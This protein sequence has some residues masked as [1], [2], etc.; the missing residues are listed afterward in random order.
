MTRHLFVYSPPV[1]FAAQVNMSPTF[2]LAEITFDNVTVGS[3]APVEALEGYTVLYGSTPGADD[4]GRGYIR[5]TSIFDNTLLVGYSSRGTFDGECNIANNDYI[6]VIADRR[7]WAKPQR[8]VL[9]DSDPFV[10]ILKDFELTFLANGAGVEFMPKANAGPARA[11]IVDPDTGVLTLDF[12][13]SDSYSNPAGVGIVAWQWDFAD[14]TIT[15][16]D[17]D[18]ETATVTFPPGF[19]YVSLTVTDDNAWE[20][21]MY[22]PVLADDPDA[23]LCVEK[24]QVDNWTHS[25]QGQNLGVRIMSELPRATYPD[26]AVVMLFDDENGPDHYC[27][28][29]GWHQND[30]ANVEFVKTGVLRDT[31]LNCLDVAGRLDTLPAQTQVIT[32]A[33]EPETWLEMYHPTMYLLIDYLLRWHSTALELADWS[34]P[35]LEY[36]L[37]FI[38]RE[39]GADTLYR[40][41]LQQARSVEVDHNV[42]CNRYG[43]LLMRPDPNLQAS[44]SRTATVQQAL[45]GHIRS[46]RVPHERP[47]RYQWIRGGGVIEGWALVTG[48]SVQVE[49]VIR[50][51]AFADIGAVSIATYPLP[52]ALA[53]DDVLYLRGLGGVLLPW[54]TVSATASL[55]ATSVSVDALTE[56]VEVWS[57]LVFTAT[58]TG[59]SVI[60]TT[61]CMAPGLVPG[62]GSQSM[63][64]NNKLVQND[65]GLQNMIGQLYAKLNSEWGTLEFDLVGVESMTP[66]DPAAMTWVTVGAFAAENIPQR[67]LALF[68]N[69]AR[70]LPLQLT[71][72]VDEREGGTFETWSLSAIVETLGRNAVETGAT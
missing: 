23:S 20:H 63:T 40:Q 62:Q 58:E 12:D 2:P 6:T 18:E 69:G 47:P 27:D 24:W 4:K 50:P 16:G 28:F 38:T 5:K 8:F 15:A 31:V 67:L 60:P 57:E 25:Q 54:V 42:G 72:N 39:A 44:I 61:F 1:V 70:L 49:Y 68:A 55:G 71:R 41:V 53:D 11:G 46:L 51:S 33:D 43:Q 59:P 3:V 7:V 14:G 26:G 37:Q 13:A 19:R 66:I 21:T 36:D 34:W 17:D 35:T 22:V 64:V 48:G 52:V 30:T 56:T 29:Y 45:S 9:S 32:G 10:T 65:G